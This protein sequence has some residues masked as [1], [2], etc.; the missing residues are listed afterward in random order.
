MEK[1]LCFILDKKEIYM[2]MCLLEDEIPIFFSCID[3]EN[4]YYVALCTDMDSLCYCVVKTAITQLRDML[5]GKISMRDII[6]KQKFFWQVVS[7]DGKVENDIVTYKTME[8]YDQEDLPVEQ[9]FFCLYSEELQKYADLIKQKVVE[10][11]FDSFPGLTNEDLKDIND[12][13]E[14][15]AQV[16]YDTIFS[17]AVVYSKAIDM[18]CVIKTNSTMSSKI[19]YGKEENCI[20][21]K[22]NKSDMAGE[23]VVVENLLNKKNLLLAA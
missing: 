17:S 9:A 21:T 14:I 16:G 22:E 5:Y 7:K 3:M 20:L 8:E 6:I 1:N 2:D 18:E 4:N 19:E 10:G 12:G 13:K 11:C 15:Y 23:K